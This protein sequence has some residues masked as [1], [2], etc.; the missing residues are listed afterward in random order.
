VEKVNGALSYTMWF[1]TE[2]KKAQK[3]NKKQKTNI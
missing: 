3:Q 2:Q 1:A